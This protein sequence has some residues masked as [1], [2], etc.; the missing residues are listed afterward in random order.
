MLNPIMPVWR[1][2]S[3]V[4][5]DFYQK[6]LTHK[7]SIALICLSK[8]VPESIAGLLILSWGA[9]SFDFNYIFLF[10]YYSNLN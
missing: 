2:K 6:Y 9:L 8:I 3:I 4:R 10:F 1:G 7:L 5:R